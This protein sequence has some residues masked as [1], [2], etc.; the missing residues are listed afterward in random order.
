MS[1]M[2]LGIISHHSLSHQSKQA[3][4]PPRHNELYIY[5]LS[6]WIGG[7][8]S[9]RTTKT[10]LNKHTVIAQNLLFLDLDSFSNINGVILG[11][12]G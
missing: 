10:I 1:N 3:D 2:D 7:P 8:Y 4:T 12:I 11:F 5:L 6:I 9:L